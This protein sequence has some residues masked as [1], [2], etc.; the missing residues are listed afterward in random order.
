[1][2][3]IIPALA[4]SLLVCA[5][6]S[7]SEPKGPG[8]AAAAKTFDYDA[9]QAPTATEAA[10]AADAESA[11]TANPS[12]A[13]SALVAL[14]QKLA[15]DAGGLALPAPVAHVH[16]LLLAPCTTANGN[17]FTFTNCSVTEG[18]I[19]IT[20]NGTLTA[21]KTGASWDITANVQGARGTATYAIATHDVGNFTATDSRITGEAGSDI[22]GSVAVNGQTVSTFALAT[23]VA[24]DL[25]FQLT[26]KACVTSGTL[27]AKLVWTKRPANMTVGDKAVKIAWT[28]CGA[29]HVS[30][31]H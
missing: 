31:S 8:A 3:N 11:F 13:A 23:S 6:G 29:F 7:S 18:T 19:T 24:L 28:G 16:A 30:H 10:A 26:P 2:R 1:M 15:T 22:S 20:V 17:T 5:C 9:P 14:L 27:E 25:G 12:D 4:C 21:S